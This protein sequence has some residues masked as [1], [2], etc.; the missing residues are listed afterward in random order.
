MTGGGGGII[1]SCGFL[2]V[3]REA[4]L[5]TFGGGRDP[6]MVALISLLNYNVCTHHG[7]R[8]RHNNLKHCN[9]ICT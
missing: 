6:L 2:F 5:I 1:K 8:R 7:E 4:K 3:N 9:M